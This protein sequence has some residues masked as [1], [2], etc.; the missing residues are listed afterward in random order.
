MKSRSVRARAFDEE[1]ENHE[2]WLVSYADFITL[3]FAFFVVMYAISSLN[4]GKYKVLAESLD[5]AFKEPSQKTLDPIQIGETPKTVNPLDA[6]VNAAKPV[7]EPV[8]EEGQEQIK[9]QKIS[10]QIEEVLAPYVDDDLVAVT[11]NE[12]WVAVEMKSGML[13]ASGSAKLSKA[14]DPVLS[15]LAEIVREMPDN[16]IYIEGHTDNVPIQT[17]EFPS[18][19]EL[20]AAR[21]ASVVR[22]L[23]ETG[24]APKRLAAV[25]YGENHP[26]A[27]NNS[28][29]G[30]YRNRRV[31]MVLQAKNLARYQVLSKERKN[32]TQAVAAP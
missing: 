19:W 24:V 8:S 25:G 18:N 20:S 1:H 4:E 31:V 21:A 14:A 32:L 28:E 6:L 30:R 9:L 10:E 23:V 13:F 16:P 12:F 5:K 26:V 22:K 3:L 27:D 7:T 2:R 17:R 11:R 15:K 29:E